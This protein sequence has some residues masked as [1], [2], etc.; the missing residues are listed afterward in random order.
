MFFSEKIIKI[1]QRV[2]LY[3]TKKTQTHSH[4]QTAGQTHKP[5]SETTKKYT[6][7]STHPREFKWPRLDEKEG[8]TKRKRREGRRN[9][10]GGGGGRSGV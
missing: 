1:A 9:G 10:G 5:K 6:Q 4:A 2:A 8:K 7:N 3:K